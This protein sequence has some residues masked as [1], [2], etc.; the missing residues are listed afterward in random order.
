MEDRVYSGKPLDTSR[1]RYDEWHGAAAE[2]ECAN[3]ISRLRPWH[4]S[5]LKLLPDLNDC[6]V[7]EIGC[8]R[9]DLS[10][11]LTHRYPRIRVSGIDFS[12]TAIEIASRRTSRDGSSPSFSVGDAQALPFRTNTFDCIVSCECLEH[13]PSPQ[14]M[15]SE[16][17]RTL[18]PGGHFILTTENYFNEMV[19]AWL[20]C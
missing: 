14:A 12:A 20:N 19:L 1:D 17:Y 13:V 3:G 4:K 15:A 7:L 5:A 11:E 8:G 9:G 18:G 16:M 6:D 2:G 10:S